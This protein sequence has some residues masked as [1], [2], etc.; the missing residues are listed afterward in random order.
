[1]ESRLRVLL[2]LAE[3]PLPEVNRDV[4]ENGQKRRRRLMEDAGWM[5]VEVT[6]DDIYRYPD[7][8]ISRLRRLVASRTR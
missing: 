5:V 8:L 4:V 1:M 6:A 2:V 7:E 3:L